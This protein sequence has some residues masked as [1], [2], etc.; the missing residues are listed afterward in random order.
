MD[1]NIYGLHC[2]V[3][4][5]RRVYENMGHCRKVPKMAHFIPLKTAK[6]IKELVLTFVKEIWRRNG[7]PESIVSNRD[8]RFT[9]KF[10]TSLMQ[11]LQVKLNISTAFHPE[12]D[13]QTERVHQQ[14]N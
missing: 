2:W 13:G 7:V 5:V 11:L 10:W 14:K 8:S 1:C 12:S 3:T 6:Q 9:S 4:K